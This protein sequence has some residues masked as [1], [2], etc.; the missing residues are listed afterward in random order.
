MSVKLTTTDLSSP[1]CGGFAITA[2]GEIEGFEKRSSGR[3]MGE[4]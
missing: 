2:K 1:P 4:I 3:S